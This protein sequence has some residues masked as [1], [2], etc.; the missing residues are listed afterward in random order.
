MLAAVGCAPTPQ[1]DLDPAA[2]ARAEQAILQA[3]RLGAASFARSELRAARTKLSK[4]KSAQ[5]VGDSATAQ[6][7]AQQAWTDAR[8]ATARAEASALER[9]AEALRKKLGQPLEQARW[10]AP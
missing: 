7:L 4:A 6:R 9:R 2:I 1:R 5:R 3:D 8:L 10:S